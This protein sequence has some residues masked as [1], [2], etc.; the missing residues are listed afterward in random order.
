MIFDFT[1]RGESSR[2]EATQAA[3]SEP[4]SRTTLS[5][6]GWNHKAERVQACF[7]RLAGEDL[8]TGI[9]PVSV[10]VEV[11]PSIHIANRGAVDIDG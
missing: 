2:A 3:Q 8:F 7:H 10:L 1:I 9:V 4:S 6:I 5:G 11:D